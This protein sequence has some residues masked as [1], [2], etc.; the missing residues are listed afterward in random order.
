[1]WA[2]TVG[3][4]SATQADLDAW[5]AKVRTSYESTLLNICSVQVALHSVQ[6]TLFQNPPFALHTTAP[7]S[8]AGPKVTAII[9]NTAAS[10]VISWTSNVYWKGGK[11]RTYLPG[12]FTADTTD[13]QHL[14]TAALSELLTAANSFH[15][16]LNGTVQGAIT[17]T[18]HGFVSFRGLTGDIVTGSFIPI[19]GAATHP[20]MGTQRGRLGPWSPFRSLSA[21]PSSGMSRC[22]SR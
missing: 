5:A 11:P 12:V 20:R 1:M 19:L 15:G 7:S 14:T 22:L 18:V 13:S 3:G 2:N 16:Q 9:N 21:L 4:T 10:K 6:C 8:A 17:T